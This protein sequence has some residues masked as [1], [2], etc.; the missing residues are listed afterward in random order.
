MNLSKSGSLRGK[1]RGSSCDSCSIPEIKI[2]HDANIK[3]E[4]IVPG[5]VPI[6][7]VQAL[8]CTCCSDTAAAQA[9]VGYFLRA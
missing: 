6:V 1:L 3:V 7:C 2:T 4:I 5:L 8:G 9:A